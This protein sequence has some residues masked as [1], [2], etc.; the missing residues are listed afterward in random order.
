MKNSSQMKISSNKIRFFVPDDFNS[1][2]T[3]FSNQQGYKIEK[4]EE[5]L[6]NC[7]NGVYEI[8]LYKNKVLRKT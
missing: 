6:I 5:R 3:P 1:S 7:Q 2:K 8:N 4:F